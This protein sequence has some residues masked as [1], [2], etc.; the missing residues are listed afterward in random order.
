MKGAPNVNLLILANTAN[1]IGT[2]VI[3]DEGMGFNG[4]MPSSSITSSGISNTTNAT[5]I[6]TYTFTFKGV[7][8]IVAS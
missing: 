4:V 6:E 2:F 7:L 3:R 8:R 1:T 5:D